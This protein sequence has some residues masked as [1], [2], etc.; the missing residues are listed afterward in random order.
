MSKWI[1]DFPANG[2]NSQ[3]YVRSNDSTRDGNPVELTTKLEGK[4][5]ETVKLVGIFCNLAHGAYHC[6]KP[7]D[8]RDCDIISNWQWRLKDSFTST[9]GIKH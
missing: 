2:G 5:L 3:D 7:G 6:I 1:L 9:I 8:L 4:N